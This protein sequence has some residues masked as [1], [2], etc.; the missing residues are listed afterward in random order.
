MKDEERTALKDFE[1]TVF[2]RNDMQEFVN[3]HRHY[4]HYV[5][6]DAHVKYLYLLLHDFNEAPSD[7]VDRFMNKLYENLD[8][9][10]DK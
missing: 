3:L 1:D 9:M 10:E 5:A 2:D 7:D 8:L 4:C 6:I